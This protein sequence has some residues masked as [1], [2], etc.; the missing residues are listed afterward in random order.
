MLC[1]FVALVTPPVTHCLQGQDF[2]TCR[3]YITP[4]ADYGVQVSL[5]RL[6]QAGMG[7]TTYAEQSG[8][9]PEEY[10]AIQTGATFRA[11]T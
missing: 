11:E 8:A 9:T 10:W 1:K 2:R 7:N 4:E 3:H 5:W 6:A